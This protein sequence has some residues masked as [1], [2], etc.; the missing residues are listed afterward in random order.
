[1]GDPLKPSALAAV[2]P[3]LTEFASALKQAE[4][5]SVAAQP[6]DQL[7][8]PTQRLLHG[9]GRAFRLNVESPTE[10]R[11][12]EIKGRP[13]LGVLVNG[14]LCGFVE[15]KAPGKG[16]RVERLRGSDREQWEK[17]KNIPNLVYTDGREWS[18]YLFGE[19]F[20]QVV[21][22]DLDH[23]ASP[24]GLLDL[25]RGFLLWEP[26][27][28][29]SPRALAEMLAPLCHLLRE[30]VLEAL[31]VEES[32]IRQVAMEWREALFPEA[33]DRQFADA[34]A[35]TITYTLLLARFEGAE[36]VHTESVEQF[37]RRKHGLLAQSLRV[38]TDPQVRGEIDL[39]VSLLER[40]ISAID[41][42]ALR[43]KTS[44][45]WLYFYED[46]LAKYDPKL[47][48]DR[49]VYYTPVEVIRC[50]CRL[51][52]ELLREPPFSKPLGFADGDVTVLDPAAG[53]G[54]YLLAA[55]QMGC[56]AAAERQGPGAI[57]GRATVMARNLHGFEIL[58]GPY[59]VAHL[60]LT[61]AIL[62]AGAELPE[63]GAHLYL[64]DTLESPHAETLAKLPFQHRPLANEHRRAQ[65]VKRD[66]PILVCLGNPP[67]DRQLID[68]D[69][70][71]TERKGGWVRFGEHGDDGIFD[72]FLSPVRQAGESVHLKNL[73]ND[74]VYFWRW[75]L[76]KVF[77]QK[78]GAGI[79]S[80]ITASSYLR[81][82][83]FA[84]MRKVMRETFDDL[85]IL[86]LEGDRLGP[87]KTENVFAI[88]TPV[89]IALGVRYRSPQARKPARIRYAR[90]SGTREAKL[91][92]LG[93]IER[94]ADLDWKDC[95]AESFAPFLPNGQGDYFQWPLLTDIFPWQHSGAQFKRTWPIGES[96]AV[97]AARWKRLAASRLA[98]KRLLFKETAARRVDES[99]EAVWGGRLP[100]L[101][102]L[103]EK[104][105]PPGLTR[106]GYRSFD[107]QWALLDP[108]FAD[109]IRPPLAAS[110]GPRQVYL[111]SLLSGALGLGPA[112][113]VTGE[114]P[115]LHHFRGS[116]GGRDVIPLYRD[117]A[118]GEPNVVR[119]LPTYLAGRLGCKVAAEDLFTYCYALLAT[120]SY[121]EEFSE[122]LAVPGPRI[123][124][125]LD[126]V[127]FVRTVR[128]GRR[129]VFL[130]TY[131]ERFTDRH[132]RGVPVGEARCTKAI[133]THAEGY[134]ES[135]T[136]DAA[137]RTLQVGEGEF[138]PVSAAAWDFGV[139]GLEVV[140]SWLAYRMKAG[141][142]RRSSPLDEIRTERWTA[143]MTDE[144]LQ[145]VWVLEATLGLFPEL[146]RN[147]DHIVAGPVVLASELPP[148]KAYER[149]AP[150]LV[151][152]E[153]DQ[154][155]LLAL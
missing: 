41:L 141:A 151:A 43:K 150:R 14:L 146:R 115:D 15:L 155:E 74:Y 68:A 149:A 112:A 109:R 106:Y 1:M 94:F 99:Y 89:A 11:I 5:W 22:L 108:R 47:R 107:R 49:G 67:Y 29:S 84:G 121:A 20:G 124:I 101:S 138:A 120:P 102:E 80:F 4:A 93:A 128:Y 153:E 86:D 132:G 3:L 57:S 97:L 51:V 70:T 53:T 26:L 136:Y 96:Q 34:Y 32:A 83:G 111:T 140:K 23:P 142:G 56:E 17:F 73:Y 144:L 127:L 44:D 95:P 45:P 103:D 88:R 123:P 105:P 125:A 116:F 42:A 81:G 143:E 58:V 69:D 54:A 61:Q 10:V 152:G 90:L 135:F 113:T 2:R 100:P 85:W 147:L 78:N 154:A 98:E 38:L 8:A 18:R 24:E 148:P 71:A 66:T 60:R 50:Q 134:P 59:A 28:P 126:P 114:V 145:L 52:A 76:W 118:A 63:D 31:G 82:P 7:K 117:S 48:K 12:A 87:R 92:Q 40:S 19:R 16:A 6:E 25:L 33:D 119:G 36:R 37:L 65:Q 133:P 137:R 64:T 139:S 21:V 72:D 77:E 104:S 55:F 35:Q 130:H 91:A 27:V 110:H 13:D 62:D 122:E 79:V 39:G 75:A 9:L 30:E 131:G 129:L 46:F